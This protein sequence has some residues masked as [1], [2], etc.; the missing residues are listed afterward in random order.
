VKKKVKPKPKSKKKTRRGAS[1]KKVLSRKKP[2]KR[3][4]A[5][6]ALKALTGAT[7]LVEAAGVG[8]DPVGCCYWVDASGENRHGKM[9]LNACKGKPNWTFRANKECPGGGG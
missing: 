7:A 3:K 8:D 9:T 1:G 6:K 5:G 4:I 2:A